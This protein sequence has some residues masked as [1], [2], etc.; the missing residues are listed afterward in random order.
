VPP[1]LLQSGSHQ[2]VALW[3]EQA[4]KAQLATAKEVSVEKLDSF[5]CHL[6]SFR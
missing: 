1:E 3:K 6:E 4:R 5:V 2:A